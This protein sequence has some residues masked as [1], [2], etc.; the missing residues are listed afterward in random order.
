MKNQI[1]FLACA[2]IMLL[3]NACSTETKTPSVTEETPRK[4]AETATSQQSVEAPKKPIEPTTQ[5]PLSE[6]LRKSTESATSLPSQSLDF[7]S[8][9]PTTWS[10]LTGWK[11]DDLIPAWEAFLQSCVSLVK[12]SLWQKSCTLATSITQ[13]DNAILRN[14]FE[15]NFKPYQV[16]NTDGS[17]EGLITGYYEPLLRG[18]R[19][20]SGRYRFPLY[21]APKE[22][23]VIDLGS[24]YP[25][26][27][28]MKLRGRLEGRNVVPYYS[29]A[30]IMNNPEILNGY[31]FLWVDDEVE[32][33]FLQIQGSGRISLE[34]GEML[35]IGYAE[36]N[37]HPYRSIGKLLVE[38]G[39]L[40]LE[41]ASMQGI[42]QWGQQNPK[43]LN[44]LLQEN[45]RFIFFRELPDDLSG[46]LGAMG[47][48]LTAGRSLAIDPRAIPQGAPVFL[49]TTWPNTNKPLQRLMVA[50]DT[51]N[52][53]KGNIRA[54][55]FWG[56]GS[57]AGNQAG[58]MKQAG[59][60]WV[61]MPTNFTLPAS[62][63]Q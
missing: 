23:L 55:F 19:N 47:L 62:V 30:E 8:L 29:R 13:P 36:H 33:F 40:P 18:S 10:E 4:S 7:S 59:K 16:L 22:L 53:I 24:I 58:K 38:N 60:M 31:E 28:D 5:Q 21:T 44:K 57:E 6:T 11:H 14:F 2:L 54:D 25:E 1:S 63:R 35:K 56:F 43:K 51:G 39:E 34:N 45:S 17:N 32:L 3:L 20:P 52:A 49:A 12:Q 42:K 26:V 61:L 9:K 46:P 15:R 50:Q 48:P 41:K 37:G 27:Q